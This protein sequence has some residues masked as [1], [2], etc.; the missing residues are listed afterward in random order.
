[1]IAADISQE[2][3]F[4]GINRNK[5]SRCYRRTLTIAFRRLKI[6]VC[7]ICQDRNCRDAGKDMGAVIEAA[8]GSHQDSI[9]PLL[10]EHQNPTL[11]KLWSAKIINNQ[12]LEKTGRE[13][14]WPFPYKGIDQSIKEGTKK[15]MISQT[16]AK[17]FPALH[18]GV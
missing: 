7:L 1:M 14:Q 9:S 3:E 5:R 4:Y 8:S 6:S 15:M 12:F 17:F 11:R 13:K 10:K 2:A 16:S 18:S